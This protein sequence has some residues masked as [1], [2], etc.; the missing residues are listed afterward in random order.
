MALPGLLARG[1]RCLGQRPHSPPAMHLPQPAE[2]DLF[3]IHI[4]KSSALLMSMGAV[5]GLKRGVDGGSKGPG[6]HQRWLFPGGTPSPPTTTLLGSGAKSGPNC[7]PRLPQ[8]SACPWAQSRWPRAGPRLLCCCPRR[9]FWT[10]RGRPRQD[11]TSQARSRSSRKG[12]EEA[13][14]PYEQVRTLP[15][16]GVLAHDGAATG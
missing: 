2:T 14:W 13:G 5:S 4:Q 1:Q 8:R 6:Q 16:L 11:F 7:S 9:T 10:Q 15:T 12:W 3:I